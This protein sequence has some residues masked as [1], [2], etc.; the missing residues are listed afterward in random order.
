M[1]DR[2]EAEVHAI[3]R[4]LQRRASQH[5]PTA[6]RGVALSGTGVQAGGP[7]YLKQFLW[8]RSVSANVMRH[9]LIPH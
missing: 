1:D 2:F 6:H 9:G 3:A 7:D 4:R 8:R 5:A